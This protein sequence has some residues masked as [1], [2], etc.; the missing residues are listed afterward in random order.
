MLGSLEL[1]LC[2][3][4]GHLFEMSGSEGYVSEKFIQTFMR[5]A[6]AEDLDKE[7]SYMQWSGEAYILSRLKDENADGF[8]AGKPY[9]RETLFWTGYLYRYW[10]YYT[11]ENSKEVLKQA[12]PKTMK[13]EADVR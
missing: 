10:H 3:M 4:Q 5:S 1:T 6:A 7:F 11:S 13:N 12:K 2:D 9:D 8:V